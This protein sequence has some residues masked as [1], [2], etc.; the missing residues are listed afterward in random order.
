MLGWLL[1]DS[2]LTFKNI[3]GMLVAVIGM[4][5]Y[6]W[7]VEVEKQLPTKATLPHAKNSMTEEEFRLLE[8]IEVAPVKDPEV[9]QPK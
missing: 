9:G 8:R 7:A 2:E 3:M 5:I 1:F 4:V 6:S